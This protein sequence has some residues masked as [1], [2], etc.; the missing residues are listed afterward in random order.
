M[1]AVTQAG[2][3][4]RHVIGDLVMRIFTV[5]GASG[6]TL[7]TGMTNILFTTNQQS[8][9]AG[10][11]SLITAMSVSGQ[12]ITFTSSSTMVSEVIMVI[13]RVG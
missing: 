2:Q 1:A 7:A 6:S 9:A 8:T 11:I 4:Q 3:P 10:S 12:T 5:S 13:A